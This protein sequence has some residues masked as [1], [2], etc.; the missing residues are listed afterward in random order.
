MITFDKLR[1][2]NFMSYG[3]AWS[4]LALNDCQ[5]TAIAAK[6]ASGKCV[7]PTTT[8][9]VRFESTKTVELFK[10]RNQLT[11]L[12]PTGPTS[13]DGSVTI[14]QIYDLFHA[15]QSVI[16]TIFVQTRFG[17]R[18]IEACDITAYDSEV[19]EVV[20]QNGDTIR[21]SPDHLLY[22]GQY[23]TRVRDLKVGDH[24][25][26][27][28][29]TFG[30][31]T[32][33]R[34]PNRANLFDIQVAQVHEYYGNRFVSHNSSILNALSFGLYGKSFSGISKGKLVNSINGKQLE[35]Q[36]EFTSDH[37]R[38]KVVRGIK[39][40]IFQIYKNDKLINEESNSRDYQAILESQIL[41]MSFKTFIQTVVIGTASFTPFMELSA[42]DRRV[43]VE[44]LLGVGILTTMN[45]LLKEKIAANQQSQIDNRYKIDAIKVQI[46]S[47]NQVIKTLKNSHKNTVEQLIDQ[48][49]SINEKIET[50]NK[51]IDKINQQLAK[52]SPANQKYDTIRANRE[53]I[54][55]QITEA[56]TLIRQLSNEKSFVISHD[57]CPTCKQKIDQQYRQSII[58]KADDQLATHK[59]T[60][61]KLQAKLE[62]ITDKQNKL[63]VILDRITQL[64]RQVTENNVSI[65]MLNN[66]VIEIDNRLNQHEDKSL[67]AEKE[68]D[69]RRKID[70]AKV[71]L[72]SK[73]TLL[74]EKQIYDQ[75]ANLLRDSGIKTAVVN[76]Y[77]P[78]IN[79]M[80]NKYLADMDFY[81]SFE[82]DSQF[83]ETIK[84]RGRDDL[85]YQN[86][87]QGEKR[88]LDM[89]II[90][91]WRYIAQLRNSCTCQN[92]FVDE[93]LDSSLDGQGVDSIMQLFRSFTDSHVVVISHR[94]SIQ[95]LEFDKVVSIEKRDQFSTITVS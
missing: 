76:Q 8:I 71:L 48:K 66:Q 10:Q 27:I 82:L 37:D 22:T 1:F 78:I 36:V 33:N 53:K 17:Y 60:I 77:L 70:Q 40:A 89:A 84:A 35:V 61:D 47:D 69:I 91:T 51:E 14:G 32:I 44:D 13:Y 72:E 41:R 42:V 24:V 68:L 7:D 83:N 52:L 4:E 85:T 92:I 21:T 3:G 23:W 57:S 43:I 34:L 62:S 29:G 38:Y 58:S 25:A 95:D 54:V 88:R 63:L 64:N 80:I 9:N 46:I 31:T 28:D 5:L 55:N 87:S 81:L 26:M 20:T 15:D 39:P 86:L 93:I 49:N 50:I 45:S 75:S 90:F 18:M 12:I 30:V 74:N 56:K 65:T 67:I 94:E 6:N 16:G 11:V 79:Q 73:E 59:Q 2:R 19:I